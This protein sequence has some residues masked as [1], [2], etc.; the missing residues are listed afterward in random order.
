M[1]AQNRITARV[2]VELGDVIDGDIESFDDL[3]AEGAGDPLLTDIDYRIVGH[4]ENALLLEVNGEPHEDGVDDYDT[5][6]VA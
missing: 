4:R 6:E 5:E 1:E 3:L 2:W